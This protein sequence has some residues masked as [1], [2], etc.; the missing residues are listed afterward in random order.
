MAEK[1]LAGVSLRSVNEA[2]GAGNVSAAHYHFGGKE[3]LIAAIVELLAEAHAQWRRPLVQALKERTTRQT[4]TVRD[5]V[6]ATYLPFFGFHHHV[7][8]Q[9]PATKFLSRLF[10]ETSENIRPLADFF[11]RPIAED[12]YELLSPILPHVSEKVLKTRIVFSLTNLI[13]GASDAF[14]VQV[15]LMKDLGYADPIELL[16]HFMDYIVNGLSA[17]EKQTPTEFYTVCGEQL[18]LVRSTASASVLLENVRSC[19]GAN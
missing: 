13:N 15:T 5:V 6:E 18:A 11:T 16:H 14:S 8:F 2:A 3:E 12:A 4:I 7:D 19:E 9:R 1:G 17:P 10:V